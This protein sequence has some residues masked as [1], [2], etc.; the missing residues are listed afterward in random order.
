MLSKVRALEI[1]TKTGMT[2]NI[3]TLHSW[4][5]I[6]Q[7]MMST[8]THTHTPETLTYLTSGQLLP[9]SYH[10]VTQHQSATRPDRMQ[11]K[12]AVSFLKKTVHSYLK[13]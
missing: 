1:D 12:T 13:T 5:V 9:V 4:V 6:I 8:P 11:L 7:Y 3:T 10:H 2:G